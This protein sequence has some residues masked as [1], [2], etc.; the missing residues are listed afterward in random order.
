MLRALDDAQAASA[1]RVD[2]VSGVREVVEFFGAEAAIFGCRHVPPQRPLGIV[3]VCSPLHAEFQ[4]NYRREV[5]IA[6]SL[7]AR[8]ILVQRFHYRGAGNSFGEADEMTFSTMADDAAAAVERA[9]EVSGVRR[10]TFLGT[11]IGAL[12]AA[13]AAERVPDAALTLWEP[14]TD[15]VRYFREMTRAAAMRDLRTGS[16]TDSLPV[17]D[18]LRAGRPVDV[19]GYTIHPGLYGS[20]VEQRMADL[21]PARANAALVVQLG[22]GTD[23]RRDHRDLVARM[24]DVGWSV[25]TRAIEAAETWWFVNDPAI[26]GRFSTAVVDATTE[27]MLATFAGDA[28]A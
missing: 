27:W 16:T 1:T 7:A 12:V 9:V 15:P 17:L 13:A 2:A 3:V 18:E 23:L 11:R 4:T 24:Q 8:G 19:L 6:R 21:L 10:I 25:T 22:L 14:T 5:A 26:V 20:L 28:T